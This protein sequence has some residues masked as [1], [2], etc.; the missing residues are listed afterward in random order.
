[1]RLTAKEKDHLIQLKMK[2]DNEAEVFIN[3]LNNTP[4][5]LIEYLEKMI[6]TLKN[7]KR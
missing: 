4:S 5:E 2:I 6:K 3:G 1:M 7:L